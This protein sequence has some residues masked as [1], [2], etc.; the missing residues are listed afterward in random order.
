[1][2]SKLCRCCCCM[3]AAPSK[4]VAVA[5]LVWFIHVCVCVGH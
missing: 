1:L 5:G 3:A 2:F 4:I